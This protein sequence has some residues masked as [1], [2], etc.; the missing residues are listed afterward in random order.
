M[1]NTI[2]ATTIGI[3]CPSKNLYL[4]Q[5]KG[6]AK[7]QQRGQ[8]KQHGERTH[9]TVLYPVFYSATTYQFFKGHI[10]PIVAV[11][12]LRLVQM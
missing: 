9:Y 2:L 3:I 6:R 11:K 5:S 12:G 4:V 7:V 10:L 8:A 1:L